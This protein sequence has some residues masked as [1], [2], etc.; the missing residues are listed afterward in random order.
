MEKKRAI[1]IYATDTGELIEVVGPSSSYSRRQVR[2]IIAGG[3]INMGEGYDIGE[4]EVG[5]D[6]LEIGETSVYDYPETSND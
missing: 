3:S 6:I 1:L 5:D 4:F 2:R